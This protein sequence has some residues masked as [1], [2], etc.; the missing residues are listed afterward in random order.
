[1]NE[2]LSDMNELLDVTYLDTH[3]H[4]YVSLVIACKEIQIQL[5][6]FDAGSFSCIVVAGRVICFLPYK[7]RRF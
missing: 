6:V 1:M 3:V 4:T 2:R 5:L 7:I